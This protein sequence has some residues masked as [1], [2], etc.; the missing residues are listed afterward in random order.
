MFECV[1][2]SSSILDWKV[3]IPFCV[4]VCRKAGDGG[5]CHLCLAGC[6]SGGEKPVA[7]RATEARAADGNYIASAEHLIDDE[8]NSGGCPRAPMA[9]QLGDLDNDGHPISS[10]FMKTAITFAW[11]SA[12]KTR[13]TVPPALAEGDEAG[14][15]E[16]CRT[17][18]SQRRW[19]SRRRDR[20]R[21]RPPA[22]SA[23]P[24]RNGARFSWERTTPEVTKNC[25]APGFACSSP[26]RTAMV[27]PRL[28]RRIKVRQKDTIRTRTAP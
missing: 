2:F 19:F 9:C 12:R 17:R 25:A 13:E 6:G 18:R 11:R 23:E 22:A 15:A 16:E 4:D 27:A 3:R 26:I 21:K 20:L 5:R 7:Q 14:A 10:L 1:V 24:G 8:E 28:S